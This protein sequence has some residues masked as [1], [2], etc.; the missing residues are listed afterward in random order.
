MVVDMY[1][2]C[3]GVL[4]DKLHHVRV[5]DEGLV[6]SGGMTKMSVCGIDVV[7]D[8][9]EVGALTLYDGRLCPTC[10]AVIETLL[11]S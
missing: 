5:A 3:I 6:P 10:R 11:V 8:V 7:Y 9:E 4:N 1:A 2:I